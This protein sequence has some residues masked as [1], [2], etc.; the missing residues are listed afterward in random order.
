MKH[1]FVEQ[2]SRVVEQREEGA[3]E[4]LLDSARQVLLTNNDGKGLIPL[5]MEAGLDRC[6]HELVATV[7]RT[8][9]LFA[10]GTWQDY[11]EN[12]SAYINLDRALQMRLKCLTV[13]TLCEHTTCITYDTLK[14]V[15]DVESVDELESLL[16][17]QCIY[18][19]L[20]VGT[21]DQQLQQMNVISAVPRD[22]SPEKIDRMIQALD[23]W[24]DQAHKV[25]CFMEEQAHTIGT[26]VEKS[27]MSA[28]WR[29]KQRQEASRK[30]SEEHARK[31]SAD[32]QEHSHMLSLS[33]KERDGTRLKKTRRR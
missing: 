23:V 8:L 1:E 2:V 28:S 31:A 26:A 15:I 30:V 13:V 22:V 33:S 7:G 5:F 19:G 12:A 32:P 24:L 17:F 27:A 9:Q 3:V 14:K 10:Y 18:P 16:M 20:V 21:L 6:S 29:E 25:A 11:V 4:S